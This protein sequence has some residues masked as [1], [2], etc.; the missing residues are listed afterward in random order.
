MRMRS[1]IRDEFPRGWWRTKNWWTE[2][3]Q[4]IGRNCAVALATGFYAGEA[5]R[6]RAAKDDPVALSRTKVSDEAWCGGM[7]VSALVLGSGIGLAASGA[8]AGS[9]ATMLMATG[10]ILWALADLVVS[11][12]ALSVLLRSRM[13]RRGDWA[14]IDFVD[15]NAPRHGR[16]PETIEEYRAQRLM[17]EQDAQGWQG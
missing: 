7:L 3:L 9:P 13:R 11:V 14:E 16:P 8:S 12:M 17:R 5:K 6:M 1:R 2:G 10:L 15:R 4:E